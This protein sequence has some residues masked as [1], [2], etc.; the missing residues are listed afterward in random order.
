MLETIYTCPVCNCEHFT[1][2][3]T[4]KDHLVSH[5][6]FKI[7]KC[8][9]CHFLFTN[10]RPHPANLGSYYK[11]DEYISHT[12]KSNNLTNTLY[13]LARTFT[14]NQKLNMINSLVAERT[15]LDFGCGTGDFLS[16]CKRGSWKVHGF[17][18]NSTARSIAEQKLEE[19]IHHD[20]EEIRHLR[21]ISIITLWHVLEHISDLNETLD[22]LVSTICKKGQI[23]IAVPNHES[24]DAKIYQQFWAAYDV[25][26]HLYHFSQSTIEKLLKNHGLKI[27]R[28]LPMKLD[29]FYVSLLSE[30][31]EKGRT[32]ML[33]S[34]INGCKSNI[35]ANKNSKNYSSLIYVAS[36]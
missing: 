29:S 14:L 24:L 18:P 19:S 34:F 21:D 20:L 2:Y 31:Y 8:S 26:R 10:P 36:K 25:P 11:S 28:I 13:K 30:K 17:E 4:C 23:L 5:E 27:N 9:N 22:V 32:N 12:D 16:T 15:I 1:H 35:Y 3:M 33:L 6:N 7:S